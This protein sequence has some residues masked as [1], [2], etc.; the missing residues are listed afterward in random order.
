MKGHWFDG[1]LPRWGILL[2]MGAIAINLALAPQ[3]FADQIRLETGD[4]ITGAFVRFEDNRLEFRTS[5]AGSLIIARKDIV[6]LGTEVV[7]TVAFKDNRRVSGRITA[8]EFGQMRISEGASDPGAVFTMDRVES[9]HVGKDKAS[10]SFRW[11]GRVNLGFT[12]ERGNTQ[13]DLVNLDTQITGR[14]RTDRL[15]ARAEVEFEDAKAG[16]VTE[17][18]LVRLGFDRFLTD[19]VFLYTYA[20]GEFDRFKDL[21]LRALISA[22]PG[23]QFY[24]GPDRN[25]AVRVGPGYMR[26]DFKGKNDDVDALAL[27]WN[28]EVDQYLFDRFVQVF[29]SQLGMWNLDDTSR[30][31]LRA[32]TGLRFP[33]R[34]GFVAT[35]RFDIRHET[36]PAAGRTKTDETY[37]ISLGYEW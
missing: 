6:A 13:K 25:L 12:R 24:E 5:Y 33:I 32:S 22:G 11:D 15:T 34:W 36:Q 37:R 2:W 16:R 27:A 29:H 9:I 23:Y 4:R 31:N 10:P 18:G 26:E 8:G 7:V 35:L 1:L 14:S 20:G 28:L 3:S 19:K 30:A 17:Q 21:D